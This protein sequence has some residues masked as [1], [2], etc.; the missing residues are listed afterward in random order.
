MKFGHLVKHDGVYYPAGTEVPIT[1]AEYYG[2][3]TPPVVDV[4]GKDTDEQKEVAIKT[5]KKYSESDLPTN[6]MKIK[7]LAK[8]EGMNVGKNTSKEELI[9][10]LL[11]IEG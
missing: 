8:S 1:E 5:T 4:S 11:S 6:Y 10:F 2:R 7:Q 3:V 9:K